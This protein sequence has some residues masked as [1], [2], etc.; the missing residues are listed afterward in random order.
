MYRTTY[1]EFHRLEMCA[2]LSLSPGKGKLCHLGRLF[3]NESSLKFCFGA[4]VFL[5]LGP[6]WLFACDSLSSVGFTGMSHQA[7][8]K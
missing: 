2:L 4:R 6:R 5:R 7:R 1:W 8:F 3:D